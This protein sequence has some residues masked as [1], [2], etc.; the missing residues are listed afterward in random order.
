M[1]NLLRVIPDVDY[2]PASLRPRWTGLAALDMSDSI[3]RSVSPIHLQ[4]LKNMGVR[5]S[6]SVSIVKDGVLWGL[7]ACHN[8]A[9]LTISYNVR[10][11]CRTVKRGPLAS[12]GTELTWHR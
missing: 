11:A 8:E 5:A 4:Y 9:P 12:K 3:L 7:I 1:R 6:A 10:A 2:K